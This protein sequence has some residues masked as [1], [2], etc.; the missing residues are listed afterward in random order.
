MW[1]RQECQHYLRLLPYYR[2][3]IDEETER[4]RMDRAFQQAPARILPKP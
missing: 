4:G 1:P 2:Y 3:P